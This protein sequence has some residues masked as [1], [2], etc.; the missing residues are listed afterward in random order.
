MT[1]AAT[2]ASI[3][4]Q[5]ITAEQ[6]LIRTVACEVHWKLG[7]I[8]RRRVNYRPMHSNNGAWDSPSLFKQAAYANARCSLT[9][10]PSIITWSQPSA[11]PSGNARL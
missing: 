11:K 1:R 10:H 8:G 9:S 5:T 6:D 2:Q 7:G 4:S 3:T